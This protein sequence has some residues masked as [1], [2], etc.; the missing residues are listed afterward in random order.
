MH[1][2]SACPPMAFLFVFLLCLQKNVTALH[3]AALKEST[4]LVDR[5]L[6]FGADVLLETDVSVVEGTGG[7]W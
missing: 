2:P 7:L 3:L 1:F 6:A 4:A 5:L